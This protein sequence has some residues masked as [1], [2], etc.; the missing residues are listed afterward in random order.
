MQTAQRCISLLLS[1]CSDFAIPPYQMGSHFRSL[2]LSWNGIQGLLSL[3]YLHWKKDL[4]S[5]T[6]TMVDSSKMN[7]DPTIWPKTMFN[8]M[9]DPLTL[10]HPIRPMIRPRKRGNSGKHPSRFARTNIGRKKPV[11]LS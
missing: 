1:I 3:E 7:L 8:P 4:L 10:L 11:T 5:T 2:H 9:T 6:L